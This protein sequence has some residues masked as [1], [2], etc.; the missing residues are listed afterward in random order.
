MLK[1]RWLE[2]SGQWLENVYQTRLV[3]A[4][5][6]KGRLV[7]WLDIHSSKL[8]SQKLQKGANCQSQLSKIT[9]GSL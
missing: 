2:E 5:N 3:L 9:K 1:Q 8:K 6:T 7:A 4:S